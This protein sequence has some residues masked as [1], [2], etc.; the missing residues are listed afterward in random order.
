MERIVNKAKNPKDAEKS[1]VMQQVGMTPQE[2][3]RI[4][5]VLKKKFYGDRVPDVR[6]TRRMR[7]E[8]LKG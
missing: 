5:L 1:D 3:Q 6:G 7:I 8:R 2:R 4:A